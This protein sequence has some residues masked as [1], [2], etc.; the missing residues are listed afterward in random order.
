[1]STHCWFADPPQELCNAALTFCIDTLRTGGHFVCK[2][3]Q[4][5]DS[6]V[7]ERQ[8]KRLFDKVHRDKP[9][10]SRKVGI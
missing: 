2:Y 4:G 10:A 5:S 9:E 8:V 6:A 7:F 1:M 3:Y